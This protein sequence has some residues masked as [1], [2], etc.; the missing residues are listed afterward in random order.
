MPAAPS[1]VLLIAIMQSI[2]NAVAGIFI[3]PK[4]AE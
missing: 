2:L 4:H 1:S 3:R